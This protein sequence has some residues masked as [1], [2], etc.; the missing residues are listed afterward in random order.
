MRNLLLFTLAAGAALITGCRTQ[1]SN[2]VQVAAEPPPVIAAAVTLHARPFTSMIPLTGTLVSRTRVEVRA[3]TTGRVTKFPKEEGDPVRAGEPLLWVEQE[4][5][6]LALKQ[7]ESAVAVSEA[8]LARSRV[9]AAHAQ[10][11]LERAQHL[12]ESGGITDKDLKLAIV[13]EQDARS[14]VRLSE[15]QLDQARAALDVARKKLADSIVRAPVDGEIQRK[16]INVGFY[17][18]PPTPVVVLVDNSRLELEAPVPSAVMAQI[19]PGMRVTFTVNSYP[20]ERFEGRVLELG[21]SVDAESRAAKV[22]IQVPNPAGRLKA[23]MFAEGE[24][25]IGT[26]SRA[27]VVPA[28]ALY[29]DERGGES[30]VFIVENGRAVR[31]K[32]TIS[33]ERDGSAEIASGLKEGDQLVTEQSLEI[34]DG[35]RVK[36]H[37]GGNVPE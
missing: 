25:L 3:E 33:R 8:A 13:N 5:Y 27:L 28:A 21:A 26:E 23:G 29:R 32:V 18:E 10:T 30:S 6:R 15:A 19:R 20:A 31:R 1:R 4:N 9:L 37:E 24:I 35:V 36:T 22:R 2:A 11:E 12:I 34:A 16:A 17:V 14:Q 7:S